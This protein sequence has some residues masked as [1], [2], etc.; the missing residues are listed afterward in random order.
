[1][2]ARPLPRLACKVVA[3]WAVPNTFDGVGPEIRASKSSLLSIN[4]QPPWPDF[5]PFHVSSPPTYP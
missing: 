5:N 4:F 3:T 1:M 2:V